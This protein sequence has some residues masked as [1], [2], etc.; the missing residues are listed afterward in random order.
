MA[1]IQVEIWDKD[2][3][4][5]DDYLGITETNEAGVFEL[6]FPKEA[7]YEPIIDTKP[8]LYFHLIKNGKEVPDLNNLFLKNADESVEAIV[9]V[10]PEA[11]K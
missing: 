10:V 5:K 8:D 7:F 11:Y 9:L 3:F 6:T 2:L 1:G 4:H